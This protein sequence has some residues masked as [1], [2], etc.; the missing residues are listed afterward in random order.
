MYAN[1]NLPGQ[2]VQKSLTDVKIARPP[3]PNTPTATVGVPAL[4]A[5]R[6]SPWTRPAGRGRSSQY[7]IGWSAL[8]GRHPG[9]DVHDM[10][11]ASTTTIST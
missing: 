2:A 9:R 3:P 10:W 5:S 1:A 11:R 8:A 7:L 4:S 6:L